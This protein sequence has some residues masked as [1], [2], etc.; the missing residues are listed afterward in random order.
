MHLEA[1]LWDNDGVLVDTERLYFEATARTLAR[2]GFSLSREDYIQTSLT[3]GKSLFDLVEVDQDQ[4]EA[5][6][7]ERNELYSELLRDGD[8]TIPGARETL[9]ALKDRV[10]MI[11]VTSSRRDHFQII[12][13]STGFLSYFEGVVDNEDYERSK[14]HPDPY[15]LGLERLGLGPDVCIAVED[16]ARGMQA[17]VS[18][19]LRC[20][21]VPSEL[22]RDA[23]FSDAYRVLDRI[24]DV[25][26]V[27]DEL[28]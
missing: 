6:R 10:R 20:T 15:R 13:H 14:P 24:E 11:V 5:L 9:T 25:V 17:A 28:M 16:S 8:L 7:N 21:V 23:D 19:G 3:D 26:G 22:T 4:H 12:H 18:A 2:V 27:V 1:I